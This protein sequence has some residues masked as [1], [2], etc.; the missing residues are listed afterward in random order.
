MK[1]ILAATDFSA[2]ADGA[3]QRAA[4]LAVER[5]L[6]LQLLHVLPELGSLTRWAGDAAGDALRLDAGLQLEQ[7]AA[8][9]RAGSGAVVD[10]QC[11]SGSVVDELLRARGADDLLVLGARGASLWRRLALGTTA[12]RL[13]R[14][15]PGAALVVRQPPVA[16]YRRL[17]L[18]V[19]FSP[20][21]PALLV[22]ARAVAPTAHWLIAHV[23]AVPH[24][25]KLYLAGVDAATVEHY[26]EG[27][28]Q[29]ALAGLQQLVESGQLAGISHSFQLLDGEPG[30]Q[31]LELAQQQ[32]ADLLAVGK[33]GQSAAEDLLLGSVAQH[34]LAEAEI[35]VLISA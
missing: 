31:L 21:T 33:R 27:A 2:S 15:A 14:R 5:G 12:E 4:L 20:A 9:L 26:R 11:R 28:R 6:P 10:A 35:D 1:Q 32:G 16:P 29:Q 7:L 13:I 18:G 30:I 23:Y 3:L 19:D 25:D 34:L 8:R 17:L 22:W 24:A